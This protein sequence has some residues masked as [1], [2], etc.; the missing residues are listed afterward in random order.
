MNKAIVTGYITKDIELRHTKSGKAVCE[1][2]IGVSRD[3][4]NEQGNYDSD[5]IT[6]QLWGN[7]AETTASYC[8][9][10]DKIGVIG[11]I[12]YETYE[13]DAGKRSKTYIFA[14]NVEWLTPKVNHKEEE[15][16][17]ESYDDKLPF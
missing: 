11:S 2:N 15:Q 9:K 5:F 4:K 8:K 12:R 13:T 3:F 1:F 10:G 16:E 7:K 14:E 17:E 6:I